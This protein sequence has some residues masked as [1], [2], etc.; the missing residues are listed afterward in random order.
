M[1]DPFGSVGEVAPPASIDPAAFTFTYP[2]NGF[3]SGTGE[4]SLRTTYVQEWNLTI[5]RE[6]GRNYAL[7]AAYIAKAGRKLIAYRP[8]N[9]AVYI[10]GT[11]AQG[12]PLSTEANAESRAP[13]LPGVYGT[14]GIYLD[15]SFT[16]AFHSMQI[17]LN[18]RYSSGLQFSTSYMLGK[19]IDSSS[20][21][22]LGAC[23]SNPFDVRADRG[24]SDFDRRHAF[25]FS[26]V[27]S[28]PVFTDQ[29]GLLGRLFGGWTAS[30]FQTIQSGSPV[31][32]T[33]GQNTALDGNICG[34]S[35]IH[36]DLVGTIEREHA[37]RADMVGEFFNRDAFA[38]PAVGR[39]GSAGRGIFSG[40]AQ[41][42]TD[43]AVLKDFRVTEMQRFQ[44]RAE[45]FN[46]FNQVNFNNPV[47]NL[48]SATYGRITGSQ[49]GRSIQ[50][51]LKYL[52]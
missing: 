44:F 21:I 34:G 32:P 37:S 15:N 24:R 17:E 28:P 48:S 10:P 1:S 19:S 9:A 47:A 25:V 4:D 20:T 43:L 3:W 29:R 27:W 11:D 26:G 14:E 46:L 5:A 52:W 39:Y 8:F 30:G 16:S 12:R 36:P 2:I 35:S 38:L 22:T 40:P 42:S 50:F 7:S 33:S 23:L 18:K 51:G 41:A 49:P 6:L 13:F 45:F 31:T